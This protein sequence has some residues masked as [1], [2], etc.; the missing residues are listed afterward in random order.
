MSGKMSELSRERNNKSLEGDGR[1][2][3]INIFRNFSDYIIIFINEYDIFSILS[4]T[5]LLTIKIMSNKCLDDHF[6]RW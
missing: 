3:Q 1:D 6:L 4:D 2:C 5:S